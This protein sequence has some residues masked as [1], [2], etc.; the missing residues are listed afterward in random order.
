MA[1]LMGSGPFLTDVL[2]PLLRLSLC[3]LGIGTISLGL[4]GFS[5]KGMSVGFG[6]NVKGLA[7][8]RVGAI[9][10]FIGCLLMLFA[11]LI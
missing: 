3:I 4:N 5:A 11:I 7:G 2:G 10:A 1:T 8:K 9:L 6:W